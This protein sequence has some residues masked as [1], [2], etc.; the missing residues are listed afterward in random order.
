MEW[1]VVLA[2]VSL[3]LLLIVIEVIFIPGT[4]LVGLVGFIFV[5]VGV[6]LS[7]RYFGPDTGWATLGGSAVTAGG[8]LYFAL[9]TNVWRRFSLKS[10]VQGRV[11][12]GILDALNVGMTGTSTSVLRPMGNAE[13]NG[14]LY[15]VRTLGEY[16][17][18]GQSVRIIRISDHKIFVE[19]F[20]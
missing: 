4:T 18:S 15:E 3:G 2:L 6:A 11:N 16:V 20:N 14:R 9:K 17:E 12:E 8:V 13:I 7:F 1:L 19:S 5:A 10:S